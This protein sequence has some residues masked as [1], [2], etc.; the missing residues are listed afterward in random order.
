MTG[1]YANQQWMI[2]ALI[3]FGIIA[4]IVFI[5]RQ[6]R[7]WIE[8]RFSGQKVLAMSFGVNYFGRDS[9]P[10]KPSRSSGFLLLLPDRLFY[11]SRTAGLELSIPG[12]SIAHVYP[13]NSIKGVNLHQSVVKIDF[14]NENDKRDS[15]AFK[16]PYPPQWISAIENNLLK[17]PS[18]S[19]QV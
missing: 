15:A 4:Y 5:R 19:V 1:L 12:K 6:D 8:K 18:S 17:K 13:D 3:F 16:V 2:I 10:G 11:R 14:I 9:E 7:K